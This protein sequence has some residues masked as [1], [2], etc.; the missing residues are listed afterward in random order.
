[1]SVIT[2]T[3]WTTGPLILSGG[4]YFAEMSRDQFFDFCQRNPD[5]PFERTAEG[6]LVIMTPT[7]GDSARRNHSLAKLLGNWCDRDGTGI[8]FDSSAG[9]WLPNGAMLSPDAAW[10][11][12]ERWVTLSADERRKFPPLAPDFVIELRSESDRLSHLRDKMQEYAEN[13]VRLG[14]LIDPDERR[15]EVYRPGREVENLENPATVSGDPELPG[16]ILD[17]AP[18][19]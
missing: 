17:L 15:V 2:P 1:M 8:A 12:R 6:D 19:W 13:G 10:V 18:V 16:F 9:F 3:T 5:V 11:R 14:W 7:G 4:S